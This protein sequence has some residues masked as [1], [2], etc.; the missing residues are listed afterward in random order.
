MIGRSIRIGS[1]TTAAIHIS[2]PLRTELFRR[3]TELRDRTKCLL[4]IFSHNFSQIEEATRNL[5]YSL[6]SE[7]CLNAEYSPN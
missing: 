3:N 1:R 7:Y 6:F 2:S 5:A 4:D